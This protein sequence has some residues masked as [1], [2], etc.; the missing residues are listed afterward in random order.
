MRRLSSVVLVACVIA[1]GVH[2]RAQADGSPYPYYPPAATAPL[3][4]NWTGFYAGAHLGGTWGSTTATNNSGIV[5]G[6]YWSAAPSGFVAG[7]QLGY[8]WQTGPLLYGVEGDLGNLGLAGSA[9]STYVPLGYDASTS[10]DSGF[11]L[12][13]RARLGVLLNGWM[14]YATG[15]YIGADTTVQV[16]EACASVLCGPFTVSASEQSFR[17]GW[18]LGGGFEA[19]VGGAWT[20]KVEYLYYDLGTETAYTV[21]GAPNGASIWTVDTDGQLVRAGLNYRFSGF[22][23]GQ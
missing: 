23:F 6:D 11:Y 20:A 21:P 3:P 15:G 8:N 7:V 17:N 22:K 9:T 19:E 16:V 14:L 2:E 1:A 12:T 10:T 4:Q 18:T 13:L 5:L